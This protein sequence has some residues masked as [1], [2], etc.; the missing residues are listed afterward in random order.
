MKRLILSLVVALSVIVPPVLP[1]QAADKFSIQIK[2]ATAED[3]EGPR[4]LVVEAPYLFQL[5][6]PEAQWVGGDRWGYTCA[7]T[8]LE[9]RGQHVARVTFTVRGLGGYSIVNSQYMRIGYHYDGTPVPLG[10]VQAGSP[11]DCR[12]ADQPYA[13]LPAGDTNPVPVI[14]FWDSSDN[15]L[16]EV[17]S[18]ANAEMGPGV[19][20][21]IVAATSDKVTVV[22]YKDNLPVG[23]VYYELPTT[24][25]HEFSGGNTMTM[26]SNFSSP[27]PLAAAPTIS[28][29]NPTSGPI[30]TSVTING[31]GFHDGSIVNDVEFNNTDATFTVNSDAQITA[32]VP[33]EAT[34]GPIEVSDSDGTAAAAS[35]FDVTPSPVPT[36]T[37]F[38]PASGTAGTSVVISGSGLTGATS[39]TFNG[40]AATYSVVSDTQ[41]TATVPATA[42]TGSIA[43]TTPGGTAIGP[44]NF[45]FETAVARHRSNITLRLS[46]HLVARGQVD[47]PDGTDACERDRLVKIQRRSG[48]NWRTVR[49]DRTSANGSYRA[50]LP[51]RGGT[52]RAVLEKD[53][54]A[55]DDVCLGDVSR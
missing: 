43:V 51:D 21:R 33:A 5:P 34:D 15:S 31:A 39:V 38:N 1:V 4:T 37:S 7:Y 47:V 55:N 35:D 25:G 2:S 52:Y 26:T 42:T 24:P 9:L 40:V 8:F 44:T 19:T 3:P 6:D 32:T 41:I 54:L 12:A 22:L 46:G 23:V 10:T 30:G 45:S 49:Q 36:I 29:F 18:Y 50:G 28:S 17:R 48:G 14:K 11:G 16:V 27:G 20:A 53:R 13:A